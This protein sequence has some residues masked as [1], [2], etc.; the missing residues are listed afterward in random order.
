MKNELRES[1][2]PFVIITGKRDQRDTEFGRRALH[3]GSSKCKMRRSEP[4]NDED[5]RR[6]S[7]HRGHQS[8]DEQRRSSE[9][10]QR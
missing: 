10:C 8:V 3:L 6:V 1:K 2:M 9:P 5:S 4:D 7:R